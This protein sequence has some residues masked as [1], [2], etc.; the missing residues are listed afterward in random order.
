MNESL[1]NKLEELKNLIE[2]DENVLKVKELDE[3]LNKS[4]EVM[5]L[6]YK[7][8]MM[9]VE[10]ENALKHFGENSEEIKQA[11]RNLYQAKLELDSHPLVKEYN[12]Y[13]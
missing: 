9:I 8:D 7:K 2:N 3:K 5:K 13:L 4:E 1:A 6:S 12:F 10:Y 11:Q